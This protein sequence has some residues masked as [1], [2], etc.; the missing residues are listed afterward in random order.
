LAATTETSSF[1]KK[2]EAMCAEHRNA[3]MQLTEA[4][5]IRRNIGM[6]FIDWLVTCRSLCVH[7][8]G[9]THTK[10]Y[11]CVLRRNFAGFQRGQRFHRVIWRHHI[12]RLELYVK[13]G[14]CLPTVVDLGCGARLV[15]K[16]RVPLPDSEDNEA[17]NMTLET[18]YGSEDRQYI[19]LDDEEE[20]N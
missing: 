4:Q 10:M 14:D 15:W 17:T 5:E 13:K 7:S 6:N 19:P 8:D 16:P 20:I 11:R 18:M 1:F 9:H 2:E 12:L 3:E